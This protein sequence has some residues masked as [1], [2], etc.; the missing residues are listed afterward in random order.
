M[1]DTSRHSDAETKLTLAD[2]DRSQPFR[3][4]TQKNTMQ[5]LQNSA[6]MPRINL[7]RK[8]NEVQLNFD[9]ISL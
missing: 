3:H 8:Q 9:S 5:S 6:Y 4:R 2:P 7:Y 1:I